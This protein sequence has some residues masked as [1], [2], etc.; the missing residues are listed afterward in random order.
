MSIDNCVMNI[1]INKI[2]DNEFKI[3]IEIGMDDEL[4]II[5]V[6]FGE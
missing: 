5:I 3:K 4:C 2:F 6:Q 1:I